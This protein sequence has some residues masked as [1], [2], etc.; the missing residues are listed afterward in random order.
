MKHLLGLQMR[1]LNFRV[2]RVNESR[3]FY[4]VLKFRCLRFGCRGYYFFHLVLHCFYAFCHCIDVLLLEGGNRFFESLLGSSDA[5]FNFLLLDF[6][7][8]SK[9]GD[10]IELMGVL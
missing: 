2:N 1:I 3:V 4:V 7:L 6:D 8:F 10:F 9:L 5:F